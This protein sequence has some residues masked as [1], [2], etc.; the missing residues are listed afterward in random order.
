MSSS[1]CSVSAFGYLFQMQTAACW[2]LILKLLGS[3]RYRGSKLPQLVFSYFLFYIG[4]LLPPA[5]IL[6]VL[7]LRGMLEIE[8]CHYYIILYIAIGHDCIPILYLKLHCHPW[9]LMQSENVSPR[10][11]DYFWLR[12]GLMSLVEQQPKMF[13]EYYSCW[14][15]SDALIHIVCPW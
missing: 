8:S 5:T 10:Y 2:R 11:S 13:W 7:S 14:K 12:K 3:A 4:H 6:L 9:L 1:K 15:F